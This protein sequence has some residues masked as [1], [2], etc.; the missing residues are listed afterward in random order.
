MLKI[1]TRS[2]AR[3]QHWKIDLFFIPV[4]PVECILTR[5]AFQ[6][7]WTR[8]T[9]LEFVGKSGF[10]SAAYLGEREE[11]FDWLGLPV[12]PDAFNLDEDNTR[13]RA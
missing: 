1:G 8:K 6:T 13:G 11:L 7:G 4:C 9:A 2:V 12:D 3:E 10:N 5:G